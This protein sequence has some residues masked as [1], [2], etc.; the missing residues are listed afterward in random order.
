MHLQVERV[1]ILEAVLLTGSAIWYL[2]S[3]KSTGKLG[4][5][6]M[7]IF[8]LLMLIINGVNIFAPLDANATVVSVSLSALTAYFVFATIAYWLD[9]KRV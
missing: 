3:T 8:V 1:Y 7:V 2:H 4:K 9:R 6:A 5:Y